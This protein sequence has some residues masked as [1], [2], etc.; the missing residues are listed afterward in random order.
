MRRSGLVL[1]SMIDMV[2]SRRGSSNDVGSARTCVL[3]R[4]GFEY[5]RESKG[6]KE[7]NARI[8]HPKRKRNRQIGMVE[9]KWD[10][11]LSRTRR[12]ARFFV[13]RRFW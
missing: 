1:L 6:R 10:L 5:R 12:P 4:K 8:K 11:D 9:I 7:R 13:V 2:P 3:R